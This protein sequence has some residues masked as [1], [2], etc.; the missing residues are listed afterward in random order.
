MARFGKFKV[1]DL[2]KEVKKFLTKDIPELQTGTEKT[3]KTQAKAQEI[4][5]EGAGTAPIELIDNKFIKNLEKAVSENRLPPELFP[6]DFDSYKN[7]L[8]Y[9]VKDEGD[10]DALI[11]VIGKKYQKNVQKYRR[12]AGGILKDAVVKDLADELNMSIETIQNRKIGDVYNVEEM[13]GAINL[14]KDFKVHLKIALKKAVSENA[15]T[16]EKA[17]AMQMVQ[18]YSSVLN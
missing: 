17:F 11:E 6:K 13:L 18:T 3:V 5:G 8:W 1:E 10:I 14:L 4:T 9:K 7:S 16:K 12:G 2:A 15:G